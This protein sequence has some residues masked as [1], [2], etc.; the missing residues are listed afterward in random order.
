VNARALLAAVLLWAGTSGC[1]PPELSTELPDL[2]TQAEEL[3]SVNGISA[4]G[5]SAN[6]ISANGISANGISANGLVINGLTLNGLAAPSFSAWFANAP[7]ASNMLMRYL[8]RCAVPAGESR[9]FTDP[10]TG[11]HYTWEGNLG[12]APSWANGAPANLLEQKLITA[13]LLAHVNQSG[14]HL[15]ISVLGRDALGNVIPYTRQELMTYSVHEACFFGNIFSPQQQ[16]LYFGTDR[17]PRNKGGVFTRACSVG[18]LSLLDRYRSAATNCAPLQ[19]A[20]SC[21]QRC[22]VDLQGGPFYRS[23][24]Y[25]G[26][27]YP[28]ITTRM[29][30]QDYGQL[31][32][33]MDD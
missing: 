26:E 30:P 5:I 11:E 25:N 15:P 22:Q 21:L 13:C 14:L 19:Y 10:E 20:G 16:V 24:T 12:L 33:S 18:G 3:G 1:E 31:V 6:G 7:A 28:A 2:E 32:A 8:V 4:N 17:N 23:C 29:R 9:S 27:T